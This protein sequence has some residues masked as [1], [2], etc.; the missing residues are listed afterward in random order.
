V[1]APVGLRLLGLVDRGVRML[2]LVRAST[3]PRAQWLWPSSW[4]GNGDRGPVGSWQ[5]NRNSPSLGQEL[6]AFSAVY[7]CINVI[8]SDISKL[9]SQVFEVDLDNGA[10]TV[11]RSDPYVK[12]MVAPNA[13]QTGPDFMFAFVQSYL[14]QGNTYCFARRNRR[15]EI[16]EMHVLN[17]Y[18]VKPLIAQDG[19]IFYECGEDFL[20]GLAPNT[21]V[22]ERDMIHHRLPLLPGYPLVGVTPIFAAAASSA[23]G[24]KILQN[25]Q[26]FFSNASRP[27]GMLTSESGRISPEA[28]ARFK[29]EWDEA[30]RGEGMGKIAV[31]H[32]GLKFEPLTINAQDAQLIEQLRWSVEDVARVFRVPPFMLGDMTKVSYRNTEQLGRVFITECLGYHIAHIE[33]RFQRAFEFGLDYEFKLDLSAMLRTEIDVRYAAYREALNAGWQ[34]INEVRAQEGLEPVKGGETPR[35]QVQYQPIDAV[36]S[37]Q[38]PS[39]PAPAPSPAPGDDPAEP[40]DQGAIDLAV[41]RA[42]VRRHMRRAA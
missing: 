18:R 12:L 7:A 34:S 30:Y 36:P 28:A 1:S 6:I 42:Q 16:Q 40:V 29:Q 23:V 15:N 13:Y 39:S 20:A 35:V 10:R 14:F 24:L 21:I 22:P 17:P 3:L 4:W 38:P 32:S 5:M 19:S 26:Q 11:L 25:S 9:P 31:M 27:S 8:A 2:G 33:Q 37:A 41:V